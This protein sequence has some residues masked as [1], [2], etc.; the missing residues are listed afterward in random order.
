ME[1]VGPR[2]DVWMMQ[3]ETRWA[4]KLLLLMLL[5]MMMAVIVTFP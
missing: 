2:A 4:E 5:M 1:M 3:N